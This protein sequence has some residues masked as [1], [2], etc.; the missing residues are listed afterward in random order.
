MDLA[1]I[2][3]RAVF[4]FI[5]LLLLVRAAG[6]RTVRQGTAFDFAVALILGDLVDDALWGEVD[7][8]MFVIASA[9]I[10]AAHAM[11]QQLVFAGRRR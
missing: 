1:R 5:V 4:A 9:V 7:A 11:S 6:K 8:A 2:A 10:V 3:V